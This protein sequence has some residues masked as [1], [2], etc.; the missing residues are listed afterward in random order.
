MQEIKKKLLEYCIAYADDRI[1]NAEIA[2]AAARDAV[3]DDTKS[4]AG[5]KYETT[6]EMM[7]QEIS[8]N[9]TQLLEGKKLKLVLSSIDLQRQTADV[10]PGSLVCTNRGNFFISISDGQII[11]DEI[12]YF[13][14]SPASPIGAALT[15]L[16]KGSTFNFNGKDYTILDIN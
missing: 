8:R 12:V 4:S 6:R 10:Q 16:E 13:A 2:I 15:R 11:A 9:E 14:V 7:Q 5:D 3:S 1:K